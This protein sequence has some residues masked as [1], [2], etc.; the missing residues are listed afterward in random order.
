MRRVPFLLS[1]VL[2]A[3]VGVLAC[4]P[5]AGWAAAQGTPPAG[6]APTQTVLGFGIPPSLPAAPAL[7]VLA[8]I[9]YAPGASLPAVGFPGPLLGV[10]EQGTF[11]VQA[12]GPVEVSHPGTGA[13]PEMGPA[14]SPGPAFTLATGDTL[15]TP[16]GTAV[17]YHNTGSGTASALVAALLP[18]SAKLPTAYPPGVTFQ[19]LAAGV[20]MDVPAASALVLVRDSFAPGAVSQAT[21]P[22]RGPVLGVVEQ[23]H[24]DYTLASGAASVTHATSS[25]TPAAASGVMATPAGTAPTTL[26]PDDSVIEQTGSR[27][28]LHNVGTE[29]AAALIV[30]VEPPMFRTSQ[31]T[32]S[33]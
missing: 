3:L 24:L 26:G 29:P 25:G 22:S 7:L 11:A 31:G 13:T 18:T 28:E 17:A 30:V 21:A 8:R 2:L 33:S 20:A 23:G 16:A 4:G 10:I 12:T 32:P 19:P 14:A 1:S 6:P 27:G 15:L 9:S 5:F